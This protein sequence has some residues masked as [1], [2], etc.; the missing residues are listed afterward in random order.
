MDSEKIRRLFGKFST[1][2]DK[3]MLDTNHIKVQRAILNKF[4]PKIKGNVLDIATGTGFVA[5]Y[6]QEETSSN[7]VGIDFSEQMIKQARKKNNEVRF[8]KGEAHELPF[9]DNTFDT[10]ICSY[11]FYWF[12]KY[13]KV[14][15]EI[16]RVLRKEGTFITLEEN[17]F[18]ENFTKPSFSGSERYLTQLANQENYLGIEKLNRKII[19]MNF[20]FIEEIRI[21]VDDSHE[22]VGILYKNE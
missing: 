19:E 8:I 21:P 12:T 1:N 20:S 22:T 7:I 14:I 13:K 2:Y 9:Q 16:K 4:L 5:N 10:V 18:N 6:I 3:H 15:E 17:F 11:G